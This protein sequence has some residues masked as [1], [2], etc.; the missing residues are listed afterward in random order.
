M[1]SRLS[2]AK[3][4]ESDSRVLRDSPVTP[5]PHQ[6]LCSA[7]HKRRSTTKLR[8]V[9]FHRHGLSVEALWQSNGSGV[10]RRGRAVVTARESVPHDAESRSQRVLRRQSIMDASHAAATSGHDRGHYRMR[11]STTMS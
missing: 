4:R 7:S 10:G 11:W 3:E 6:K 9:S 1:P 8:G 5:T 2:A